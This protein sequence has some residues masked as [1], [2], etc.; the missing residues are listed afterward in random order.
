MKIYI[1]LSSWCLDPLEFAGA[2]ATEAL[3]EKH[4]EE[5]SS[6][7]HTCAIVREVDLYGYERS[8]AK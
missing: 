5:L 3:A 7:D 8:E 1:V 6:E 4:A 2:Y